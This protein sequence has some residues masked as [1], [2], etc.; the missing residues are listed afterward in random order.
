MLQLI[1]SWIE[2]LQNSLLWVLLKVVQGFPGG[3]VIKKSIINAGDTVWSLGWED[4]LQKEM[5]THSN[6]LAWEITWTEESAGLQ[7]MGYQKSHNDLATKQQQQR[8]SHCPSVISVHKQRIFSWIFN[9]NFSVLNFRQL[10]LSYNLQ[11]IK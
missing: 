3:S 11:G 6:I 5:A 1:I 8:L 2:Y 10:L 4:A 7:S 9:L